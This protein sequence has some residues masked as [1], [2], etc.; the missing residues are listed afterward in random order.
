MAWMPCRRTSPSRLA[1]RWHLGRP[2]D[3]GQHQR[4]VR[5]ASLVF[6]ADDRGRERVMRSA[7]DAYPQLTPALTAD[8]ETADIEQLGQ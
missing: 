7:P 2:A 3:V 8:L 4:T 6:R 5:W 1:L